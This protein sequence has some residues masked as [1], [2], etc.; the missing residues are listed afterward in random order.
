MKARKESAVNTAGRNFG[1]CCA[2][3]TRAPRHIRTRI[4][5]RIEMRAATHYRNARVRQRRSAAIFPT[6]A[7]LPHRTYRTYRAWHRYYGINFSSIARR[8]S[9]LQRLQDAHVSHTIA[10]APAQKRKRRR[11][12]CDGVVQALK[13]RLT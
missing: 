3:P 10:T 7:S 4:D 5:T 2:M 8:P 13:T 12:S 1:A 9:N 6:R 11:N